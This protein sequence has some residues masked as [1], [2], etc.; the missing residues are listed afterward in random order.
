MSNGSFT[1]DLDV[2]EV[3]TLTTRTTGL[4]GS[5]PDPPPSSPFPKAYKDDFNVRKYTM[6]CVLVLILHAVT[7][8]TVTECLRC[9]VLVCL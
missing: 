1:L 2:D 7:F 6:S 4:K 5:Y 9:S 3:Y 8:Y